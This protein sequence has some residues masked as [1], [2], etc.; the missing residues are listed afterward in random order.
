MVRP[1]FFVAEHRF[2]G[3]QK[4]QVVVSAVDVVR[5]VVQLL[6]DD[7][8]RLEVKHQEVVRCPPHWKVLAVVD[9][10]WRCSASGGC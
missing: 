3:V 7:D 5:E 4:W 9:H 8:V 1:P 2:R 6:E 10:E